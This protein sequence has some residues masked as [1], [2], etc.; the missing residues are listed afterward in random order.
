MKMKMKIM[1]LSI[2]FI[3]CSNKITNIDK[4]KENI[5]FKKEWDENINFLIN[6]YNVRQNESVYEEAPAGA[7]VPLVI[8][9]TRVKKKRKVRN[10][11]INISDT[12][13]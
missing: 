8:Y 9:T 3:S 6:Y 4:C 5:A 2:I 10:S 7:S 1:L 13:H 11:A 12:T